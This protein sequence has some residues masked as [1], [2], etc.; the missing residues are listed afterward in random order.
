VLINFCAAKDEKLIFFSKSTKE[1]D[2]IIYGLERERER[3]REREKEITI[4]LHNK[5]IIDKC[6]EYEIHV[7]NRV[8]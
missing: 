5:R 8:L 6:C 2:D 1:N 4:R 7:L 3:E